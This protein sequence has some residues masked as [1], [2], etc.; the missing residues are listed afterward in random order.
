LVPEHEN[1][2]VT[3]AVPIAGVALK[4]LHTGVTGVGSGGFVTFPA[5]ATAKNVK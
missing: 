1:D 4:L 2:D 3:G 5:S